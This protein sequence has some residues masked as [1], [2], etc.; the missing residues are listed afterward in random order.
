MLSRRTPSFPNVALNV[1]KLGLA[2]GT[3]ER[4]RL[5]VQ[6]TPE[7]RRELRETT[8]NALCFISAALH[9]TEIVG[10]FAV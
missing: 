5:S 6:M 1:G 7:D 3:L 10:Q 4:Q 8:R 2:K 9:R